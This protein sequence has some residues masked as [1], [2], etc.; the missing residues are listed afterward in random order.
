L[1]QLKKVLDTESKYVIISTQRTEEDMK[2]ILVA[3]RVAPGVPAWDILAGEDRYNIGL[4]SCLPMEGF[5][6]K[7]TV[8]YG[9]AEE[10][11]EF[12]DRTLAGILESVRHFVDREDEEV[13][14]LAAAEYYAE[15]IAPMEAA[16]REAERAWIRHGYD[17][18]PY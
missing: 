3:K 4:I 17:Q 11:A 1:S 15:V 16:E 12:S 9:T 18:E 13:R 14:Q 10:G 6:Y 8:R 2:T 7:A 5:L